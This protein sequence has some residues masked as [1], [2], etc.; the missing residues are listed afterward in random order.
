MY[1][2]FIHTHTNFWIVFVFCV[3]VSLLFVSFICKTKKTHFCT[4]IQSIRTIDGFYLVF[5]F[6]LMPVLFSCI[7]LSMLSSQHRQLAVC[8]ATFSDAR[9]FT[10]VGSIFYNEQDKRNSLVLAAVGQLYNFSRPIYFAIFFSFRKPQLCFYTSLCLSIQ[11]PLTHTQ[12]LKRAFSLRFY[13]YLSFFV[14]RN[15]SVFDKNL[16]LILNFGFIFDFVFM[17]FSLFISFYFCHS[18]SLPLSCF[19]SHSLIIIW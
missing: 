19:L 12:T 17:L 9:L 10:L 3:F 5:I 6:M 1:P 4:N 13:F 18:L 8:V 11:L 14:N 16:F 7:C 15:R 2:Y